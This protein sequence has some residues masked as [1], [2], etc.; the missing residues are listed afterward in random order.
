MTGQL[1]GSMLDPGASRFAPPCI[2][3]NGSDTLQQVNFHAQWSINPDTPNQDCSHSRGAVF[4][5]PSEGTNAAYRSGIVEKG[6]IKTA[7]SAADPDTQVD[8]QL[9]FGA[10]CFIPHKAGTGKGIVFSPNIAQNY[11]MGRVT[12]GFAILRPNATALTNVQ[13]AGL[14]AAAAFQ[15]SRNMCIDENGIAYDL[16]RMQTAAT[17]TKDFCQ[18]SSSDSA[19][20]VV[21]IVGP[22]IRPFFGPPAAERE[23]TMPNVAVDV[24]TLPLLYSSVSSTYATPDQ[25]FSARLAAAVTSG[26]ANWVWPRIVPGQSTAPW[27]GVTITPAAEAALSPDPADFVGSGLIVTG[28][29]SVPG[30]QIQIVQENG[31]SVVDLATQ[32]I[33][34]RYWIELYNQQVQRQC[35]FAI[36]QHVEMNTGS[37]TVGP[38]AAA[39]NDPAPRAQIT[40][41][42]LFGAPDPEIVEGANP[43]HVSWTPPMYSAV[44][45]GG[46][47]GQGSISDCTYTALPHIS[48]MGAPQTA[49]SYQAASFTTPMWY[50]PWGITAQQVTTVSGDAAPE[51]FPITSFG[52]GVDPDAISLQ[53]ISELGGAALKFIVPP[54]Q[55]TIEAQ[56]GVNDA[57][58]NS[59]ILSNNAATGAVSGRYILP[60][61]YA[62]GNCG[63]MGFDLR[64]RCQHIYAVVD[65]EGMMKMTKSPAED[66]KVA[67]VPFTSTDVTLVSGV[68]GAAI[69]SSTVTSIVSGEATCYPSWLTVAPYTARG[70]YLGTSAQLYWTPRTY[71][72]VCSDVVISLHTVNDVPF[73]VKV[74]AQLNTAHT[75]GRIM[76]Y[77]GLTP[78]QQMT[79]KGT[80]IVQAVPVGFVK[81][82]TSAV[83][84]EYS[85]AGELATVSHVN[86]IFNDRG[87]GTLKRIWTWREYASA[88]QTYIVGGKYDSEL[89]RQELEDN[90]SPD[91]QL[92]AH[93]AGLFGGISQPRP[94]IGFGG[95]PNMRQSQ[96]GSA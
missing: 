13:Q 62:A 4:W 74:Q 64:A 2:D 42:S 35:L 46:V 16:P 71:G 82:L 58:L 66:I 27:T 19:N 72:T 78:G 15:D 47:E 8:Y 1:I 89:L 18:I 41:T 94:M 5:F 87:I 53:G 51:I 29:Y 14:I 57:V 50:S 70:K 28:S 84:K 77:D 33:Q 49:P 59:A 22:D 88:L 75:P 96:F 93:A 86:D 26:T 45:P 85:V 3:A 60:S 83:N 7:Y 76:K 31:P 95:A 90:A 80:I 55:V 12:S 65:D 73:N 67:Y 9:V 92:R 25:S 32:E 36:C 56:F 63:Y 81:Q 24:G 30:D 11:A 34:G 61:L 48:G 54:T 6:T 21:S 91:T 38:T 79:L 40:G 44:V 39:K 43:V 68:P 17:T 23:V 37:Y 52:P 20:G 10:E 69:A